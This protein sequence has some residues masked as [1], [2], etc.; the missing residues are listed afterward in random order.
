M[1]AVVVLCG[2]L[3]KTIVSFPDPT[4]PSTDRFWYCTQGGG[5]GDF[6]HVSVFSAGICAGPIA[7][8]IVIQ[9]HAIIQLVDT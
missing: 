6:C 9:R 8:Q 7:L 3:P 1:N 2:L 4:N 5:S